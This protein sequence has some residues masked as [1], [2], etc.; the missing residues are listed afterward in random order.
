MPWKLQM[1]RGSVKPLRRHA[2]AAAWLAWRFSARRIVD[3]RNQLTHEYAVVDDS[4]VWAIIE[5]DVPVL[6]RECA[7]RLERLGAS[8]EGDP[9]AG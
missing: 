5:P 4:I 7:H 9:G 8:A 3:F 6:R 1:A 2:G